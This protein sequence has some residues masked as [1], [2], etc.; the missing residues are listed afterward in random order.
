MFER[1][2]FIRYALAF[3]KAFKSDDWTGVLAHFHPDGAYIVE[4]TE[5][6]FDGVHRG[7]ERVAGVF[8]EMLDLV[9]RRYDRRQ[10]GLAGWPRVT[11]GELVLPWKAKY[12][13]GTRATRITGTSYVRWRDG[14]IHELRDV[15]VADEV[16]RWVELVGAAA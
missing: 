16:K 15:M 8:K 13:L 4:G 6:R 10:A 11:R 12:T 5:T 7:H 1:V 9:D 3:E 2:R 14:L